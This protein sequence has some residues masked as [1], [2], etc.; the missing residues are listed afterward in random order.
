MVHQ[1][2]NVQETSKF[3]VNCDD[4][5]MLG[6]T[7][8]DCVVWSNRKALHLDSRDVTNSAVVELS[9]REAVISSHSRCV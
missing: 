9:V 4:R 8:S 3:P 2:E 5:E 7:F 1:L 6:T